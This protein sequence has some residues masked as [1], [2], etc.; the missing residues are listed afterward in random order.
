MN[1]TDPPQVSRPLYTEIADSVIE[2]LA[3]EI[4]AHLP[5]AEADN[6]R[7]HLNYLAMSMTVLMRK[8]DAPE[9]DDAARMA[10][11]QKVMRMVEQYLTLWYVG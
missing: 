3:R 1:Y 2:T 4:H 7:E 9:M 6:L 10:R 5:P 11:V 8:N